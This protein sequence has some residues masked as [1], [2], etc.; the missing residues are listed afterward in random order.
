M[1]IFLYLVCL[2]S[3]NSSDFTF[4]QSDLSLKS[5]YCI[6]DKL[7]PIERKALA[8]R[9]AL[10][11]LELKKKR[12]NEKI[13]EE[14]LLGLLNNWQ[15]E[16]VIGI[17]CL[18]REGYDYKK[19]E[20]NIIIN[21]NKKHSCLDNFL[22]QIFYIIDFQISAGGTPKLQIE[23]QARPSLEPSELKQ[24]ACMYKNY[25]NKNYKLPFEFKNSYLGLLE[26]KKL[27]ILIPYFFNKEIRFY[28]EAYCL[29][30]IIS[31]YTNKSIDSNIRLLFNG[32][33]FL[34]FIRTDN[35][36]IFF[37]DYN[38]LHLNL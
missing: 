16:S 23:A 15:K 3:I 33:T 6:V 8:K 32:I 4:K 11:L 12:L 20:L 26:N 36:K 22:D 18:I 28:Y 37:V 21:F 19:D 13:E 2:T 25:I 38:F 5:V 30:A 31:L 1:R 17:E 10:D 7:N 27:N 14:V 35:G 34:K 24:L 9:T 29:N